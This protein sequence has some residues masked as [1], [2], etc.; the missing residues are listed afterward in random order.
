M[1][2]HREPSRASPVDAVNAR[3][4]NQ[5]VRDNRAKLELQLASSQ[6]ENAKLGQAR[7]PVSESPTPLDDVDVARRKVASTAETGVRA[8]IP[9]CGR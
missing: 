1:A 4:D 9:G 7:R 6:S 2:S 3:R 8:T 5:E